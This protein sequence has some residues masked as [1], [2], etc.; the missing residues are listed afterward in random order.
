MT[1]R[2]FVQEWRDAIVTSELTATQRLVAFVLS[3][4]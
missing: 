2:P 3:N 1:A 4:R